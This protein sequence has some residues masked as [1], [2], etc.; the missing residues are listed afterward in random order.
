MDFQEAR[1]RR[2]ASPP[3]P[4]GA[5]WASMRRRAEDARLRRAIREALARQRSVEDA[6]PD[7]APLRAVRNARP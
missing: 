2:E 6:E 1:H 7:P 4:A 3:E 5:R